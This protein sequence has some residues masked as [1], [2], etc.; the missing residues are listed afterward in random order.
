MKAVLPLVKLTCKFSLV[1]VIAVVRR[2][3]EQQACE[4]FYASYVL[5]REHSYIGPQP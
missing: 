5:F 4:N 3:K 1:I 2:R